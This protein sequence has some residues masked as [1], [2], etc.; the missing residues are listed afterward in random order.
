MTERVRTVRSEGLLDSCGFEVTLKKK[1]DLVNTT[2]LSC[3]AVN[4]GGN[5]YL[6]G[7][8][9]EE[10]DAVIPFYFD[11]ALWNYS[12]FSH[13]S[14]PFDVSLVAKYY[15]NKYGITGGGHI[16]AAGWST[17]KCIFDDMETKKIG[18]KK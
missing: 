10:Y 4:S 6:F 12:I 16:H 5:S 3:L 11:G 2:T 17:P 13:E 1:W 18:T 7:S 15:L 8:L 14:K 9:F